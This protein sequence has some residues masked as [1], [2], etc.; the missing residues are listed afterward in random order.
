M[1]NLQNILS[2]F[3]YYK[4]T[5]KC[6]LDSDRF[7][8]DAEHSWSL[9]Y[10]F[11]YLQK[12]LELE[13]PNLDIATIFTLIA[14]HDIGEL[15]TGDIATWNKKENDKNNELETLNQELNIKMNR[16]DLY[17]LMCNYESS[18]LS[19]EMQIVRSIDRIAPVFIRIYSGIGWHDITEVEHASKLKLDERQLPR[20]K[21][22]STMINLY[23][24]LMEHAQEKNLF[25]E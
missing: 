7:E 16:P 1:E 9:A 22:S 5:R 15:G 4:V 12:D 6:K 24:L 11:L 10:L 23:Q 20:H 25:P 18:N 21:F 17:E 13:F 2:L 3:D 14:I 19:V 8:N